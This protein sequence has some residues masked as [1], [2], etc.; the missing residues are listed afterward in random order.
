[1]PE[2]GSLG[3]SA[4]DEVGRLQGKFWRAPALR[5]R[6]KLLPARG[7]SIAARPRPGQQHPVAVTLGSQ[8]I[9]PTPRGFF[10]H[11]GKPPPPMPNGIERL[12]LGVGKP[13]PLRDPLGAL[14]DGARTPP[15]PPTPTRP[16]PT[17]P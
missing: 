7:I 17:Q 1:M 9:K 10:A 13:H 12:G 5:Q 4:R 3:N 8:S 6:R 15:A 2:R 16:T 14:G 11:A